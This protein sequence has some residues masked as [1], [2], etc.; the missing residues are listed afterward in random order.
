M[1]ESERS[2]LVHLMDFVFKM[3]HFNG[4]LWTDIHEL[5]NIKP[6]ISE[7]RE[8]ADELDKGMSSP[9]IKD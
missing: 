4:M 8:I 9:P 6:V 7:M 1:T 5:L 2:A 3:H